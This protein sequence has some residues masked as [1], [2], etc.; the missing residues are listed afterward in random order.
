MAT[1]VI[2]PAIERRGSIIFLF[3]LMEYSLH[4]SDASKRCNKNFA[5]AKSAPCA[6]IARGLRL[7]HA[8]CLIL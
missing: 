2:A 7:P 6:R 1:A 8:D 5:I 3:D 4:Y